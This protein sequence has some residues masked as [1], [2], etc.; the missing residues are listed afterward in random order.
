MYPTVWVMLT[1]EVL[2]SGTSERE[3][4]EHIEHAPTDIDGAVENVGEYYGAR[5]QGEDEDELELILHWALRAYQPLYLLQLNSLLS[6]SSSPEIAAVG[7]GDRIRRQTMMEEQLPRGQPAGPPSQPESE[8]DKPN[9]ALSDT[10]W[11]ELFHDIL[12]SQIAVEEIISHGIWNLAERKINITH[13][14]KKELETAVMWVSRAARPLTVTELSHALDPS[15]IITDVVALSDRIRWKY[16]DLLHLIYAASPNTPRQ[17]PGA[18]LVPEHY[19]VGITHPL[20]ETYFASHTFAPPH[21]LFQNNTIKVRIVRTCLEHIFTPDSAPHA[22]AVGNWLHHLRRY[23]AVNHAINSKEWTH[24]VPDAHFLNP[25]Y[26]LFNDEDTLRLWRLD[27][28]WDLYT[29]ADADIVSWCIA[30]WTEDVM[31]VD[32]STPLGAW[33][34]HC[35]S[36]PTNVWLGTA[37]VVSKE[38]FSGEGKCDVVKGFKTLVR[39]QKLDWRPPVEED[40]PERLSVESIVGA[41]EWL[42]HERGAVWMRVVGEGLRESGWVDEAEGYFEKARELETVARG[43]L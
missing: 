31:T 41:A 17:P 3:I 38:L 28:E 12:E 16:C 34:M 20:F 9:E 29:L 18:P 40:V 21:T 10:W 6:T 36:G 7:L 5:S 8:T 42:E 27:A 15:S 25:L 35:L 30:G 1:L 43:T 13:E 2:E 4:F 26:Q 23:C 32:Q 33:V 39:I 19:V 24:V 11:P 14:E 37:D 22:Y